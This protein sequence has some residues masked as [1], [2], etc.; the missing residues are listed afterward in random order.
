MA[1]LKY[2]GADYA[3]DTA[4]DPNDVVTKLDVDNEFSSAT[5]SQSVVQAQINAAA[6]TYST[7]TSVLAALDGYAQAPF[8]ATEEA[9]L[10][11][12]T[13]VPQVAPWSNTSDM[14]AF[15]ANVA[16]LNQVPN[17]PNLYG[18]IAPLDDTGKIPSQYVP[19]L[20]IGYCQGPYGPTATATQTAVSKPLKIA[21][22]AIGAPQIPFQPMVFMTLLAS[23]VLGGRPLV[24]VVL[25]SGGPP[26]I[27]SQG[28]LVAQGIGRSQWN[29]PN[30]QVVN[31]IPIPGAAGHSGLTTSSGGS[32]GYLPTY[33]LWLSA[34]VSDFNQQGVT[35]LSTNI[36]N[37]SAFL[38]RYQ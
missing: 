28:V 19:S 10:I 32:P 7:E 11:P 13:A 24:Q 16:I 31:V 26:A 38:V 14:A 2:V 36:F 23:A 15:Q 8:L 21:D 20:G 34:W 35:V 6:A 9:G 3:N 12:A 1:G 25:S 30:G 22:W 37:A 17:Q 27:P 29:D 33:N 4:N 5:V 18:G